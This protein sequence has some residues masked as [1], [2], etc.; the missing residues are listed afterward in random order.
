MSAVTNAG[1]FQRP[2]RMTPARVLV[3]IGSLKPAHFVPQ[4]SPGCK[5][6]S[7]KQTANR[8]AAGTEGLHLASRRRHARNGAA[9]VAKNDQGPSRKNPQEK[10]SDE[11]ILRRP[12]AH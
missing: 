1:P 11:S 2:P 8:T 7:L 5:Q 3:F 12:L 9:G 10:H 4:S 6:I